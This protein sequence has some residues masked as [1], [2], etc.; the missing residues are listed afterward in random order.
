MQETSESG[1]QNV[2][3]AKISFTIL[4]TEKKQGGSKNFRSFNFEDSLMLPPEILGVWF[5]YWILQGGHLS[6]SVYK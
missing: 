4:R 6:F 2:S 1:E 5:G 3:V